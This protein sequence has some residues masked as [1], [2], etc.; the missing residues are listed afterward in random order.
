MAVLTKG[1][2]FTTNDQVSAANL[3]NLVDLATFVS[4]AVD[5][6]TTTLSGGAI[7]VKDGGITEA[8]L[9]SGTNGQL[10]IGDG[11]GF[12]KATLTAGANVTVTNAS[13]AITIAVA[14]GI[15]LTY[16]VT[17][18]FDKTDTTL[19]NVTGLSATITSGTSYAFEVLL[20]LTQDTTGKSK[21]AFSGTGSVSAILASV[22]SVDNAAIGVEYFG[23]ITALDSGLS[24]TGGVPAASFICAKGTLVSNGTGTLTVQYAQ[25]STNGTSSV[26]VGS[27]FTI[28]PI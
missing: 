10:F 4:G 24:L 21:V 16:R 8:K 17:S 15:P 6:S 9:E 28:W 25:A 20:A 2:D 3:D 18:Q 23:R 14:G 19:A 27:Y 11:T 7:I 13:G 1:V 5:N 26:L 22:T 12:T